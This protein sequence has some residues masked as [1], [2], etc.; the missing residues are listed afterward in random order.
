[1]IALDRRILSTASDLERQMLQ[2]KNG[3]KPLATRK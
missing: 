3:A 2:M 1:M